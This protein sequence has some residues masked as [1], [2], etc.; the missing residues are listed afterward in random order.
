MIRFANPGSDMDQLVEIFKKIYAQLS[1]FSSFSLDNMAD[2][3][4]S[5]KMAS[6]RGYVG[7]EALKRS[8]A[9]EDTSRNP[10][11]NQAKMY[12]EVYRMFGWMHSVD[13]ALDF[14]FTLLGAHVALSGQSTKSIVELCLFGIQFPN[15]V[16]D[17]RFTNKGKPY[18][19]VLKYLHELDGILHRDE[20]IMGAL[21]LENG[22]DDQEFKDSV[23][24]IRNL[25]SERN[26]KKALSNAM[27]KLSEEQG[28]SCNTMRNYTRILIS[29]LKYT[30]WVEET[31]QNI[32]GRNTKFLKI[33]DYGNTMKEYIFSR[34]LITLERLET[35]T[36]KEISAV[37]KVGFL[38]FLKD[39]NFSVEEDLDAL[40]EEILLVNHICKTNDIFFNPFQMYSK[41][42]LLKY[43]PESNLET[44]QRM[45]KEFTHEELQEIEDVMDVE[46]QIRS[47]HTDE[48]NRNKTAKKINIL[49]EN[50][51][52]E[53]E[54]V[55]AIFK[56]EILSMKQT[57]FYPLV[58]ELFEII[59]HLDAR[60]SQPGVNNERF[61]V[62]IPDENFS[63]PVE[64]K[65]PTEELMLSVKA[66]RQA[67][68]NKI[69]L[70]SRKSYVTNRETS[71]IAIG[72]NIPNKRS[73]VYLLIDDIKKVF[74]INIAI[75]SIDQLLSAAINCL[76]NKKKYNIED[77]KDVYGVIKFEDL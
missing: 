51:H 10:L 4:T 24:K 3:M 77:F 21:N 14:K 20:I 48:Y 35:L 40:K 55:I 68:E 13:S 6:S 74:N 29:V 12:A 27:D 64:V 66:I 53:A 73:D 49:L 70:L 65:S 23:H 60:L 47:Q 75:A 30:G 26:N 50:N 28:I 36:E 32:Y 8:Y 38:N 69:I 5:A 34:D 39:A 44:D 18:F 37:C 41:K 63:I 9:E 11:Y 56:D 43:F 45:I 52:S 17:V 71:S 72:F 57:H 46:K 16:L 2:V 59:F 31:T 7:K 58:A 22:E 62:I 76:Q 1:D 54:R 15:Q 61:D 19:N 33:T 42:N 25:R 67:L